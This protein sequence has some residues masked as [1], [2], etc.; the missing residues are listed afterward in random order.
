MSIKYRGNRIKIMQY[1][2][3]VFSPVY[4]RLALNG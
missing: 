4:E 2:I 3:D 1:S